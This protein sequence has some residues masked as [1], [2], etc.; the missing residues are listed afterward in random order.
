MTIQTKKPTQTEID[1]FIF[2]YQNACEKKTKLQ[3]VKYFVLLRKLEAN[4]QKT[5]AAF[6][7][8]CCFP[9][10]VLNGSFTNFHYFKRLEQKNPILRNVRF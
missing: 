10:F 1:K 2:E 8:L 5:G 4:R 7:F 3:L 9:I 6:A